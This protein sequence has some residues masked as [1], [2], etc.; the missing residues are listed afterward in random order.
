MSPMSIPGIKTIHAACSPCSG[1]VIDHQTGVLTSV[2]CCCTID[3]YVSARL[4]AAD[5]NPK[6]ESEGAGMKRSLAKPAAGATA[7]LLLTLTA[8]AC[9]SSSSTSTSGG[10]TSS[11]TGGSTSGKSY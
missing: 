7:V 4:P 9:S 6:K 5:L 11:S 10:A 2:T 8:A 3:P 1:R